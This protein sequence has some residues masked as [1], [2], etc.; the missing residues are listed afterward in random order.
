MKNYEENNLKKI[1]GIINYIYNFCE[2]DSLGYYIL[3]KMLYE[4]NKDYLLQ[5]QICLIDDS[6]V[7]M[8][9]GACLSNTLDL[10]K[11]KEVSSLQ[12]RYFSQYIK[13]INNTVYS[14]NKKLFLDELNIAA[15]EIIKK[16]C[17]EYKKI[18][19]NA[20]F[21]IIKSRLHNKNLF[22]EY[23]ETDSSIVISLKKLYKDNL[24]ITESEALDLENITKSNLELLHSFA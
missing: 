10:L 19:L 11:E 2:V 4:I 14:Q 8:P 6:L 5:Y 7:S 13:N 15:E 18:G 20:N 17:L 23:T 9:H 16:V 12:K 22:P 24:K 1:I 21:S 3:T